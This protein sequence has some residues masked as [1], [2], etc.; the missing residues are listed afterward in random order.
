[1]LKLIGI[2]TMVILLAVGLIFL[3]RKLKIISKIKDLIKRIRE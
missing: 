1:M 3:E 2:L